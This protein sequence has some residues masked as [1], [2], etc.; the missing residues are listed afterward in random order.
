MTKEVA[1]GQAKQS[2][3]SHVMDFDLNPKIDRM[4]LKSFKLRTIFLCRL[5]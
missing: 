2:L 4:P 1:R 3:I 5:N